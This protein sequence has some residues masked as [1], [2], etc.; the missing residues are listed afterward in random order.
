MSSQLR[1]TSVAIRGPTQLVKIPQTKYTCITKQDEWE[2]GEP[3]EFGSI[4]LI[5]AANSAL[6]GLHG[7]NERVLNY[8]G[9]G[10]TILCRL[11]VRRTS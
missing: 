6:F 5:D 2:K 3:I 10:S 1:A 11:D 4:K 8:D 7:N 9:V